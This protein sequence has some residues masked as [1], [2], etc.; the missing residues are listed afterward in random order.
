MIPIHLFGYDHVEYV[1]ENSLVLRLEGNTTDIF[2]G[3]DIVSIN[4]YITR[5]CAEQDL[6]TASQTWESLPLS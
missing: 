6:V 2:E 3:V 1:P 4:S 5:W